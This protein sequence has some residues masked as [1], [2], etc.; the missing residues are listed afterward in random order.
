MA[1]IE[2]VNYT[3]GDRPN[4]SITR[5]GVFFVASPIFI[6]AKDRAKLIKGASAYKNSAGRSGM[7]CAYNLK[8]NTW[9][10]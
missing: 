9:S 5:N 4:K 6:Q 1:A 10:T 3:A 2:D 7:K 8:K